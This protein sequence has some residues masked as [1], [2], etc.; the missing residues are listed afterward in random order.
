MK[1]RSRAQV[2]KMV[3]ALAEDSHAQ[4]QPDERG[5]KSGID[6]EARVGSISPGQAIRTLLRIAERSESHVELR[7]GDE[8]LTSSQ[9][10]RRFG[11]MR[12]WG[13]LVS[14]QFVFQYGVAA[15]FG[16]CFIQVEERYPGVAREWEEW[17]GSFTARKGFVQAWVSDS[18]YNRWQNVTDPYEYE[19]AGRD[20]SNLRKR[21]NGLP[22]PLEMEIVDVSINPGRWVLRSGYVEAIG[23]RMVS[24]N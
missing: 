11:D 8:V 5:K 21:S 19:L 13:E 15:S 1:I 14:Q 9:V 6:F 12:P 7:F 10:L 3:F 16:H 23:S 20:C 22:P 24:A 17:L 2:L 4:S 18:E